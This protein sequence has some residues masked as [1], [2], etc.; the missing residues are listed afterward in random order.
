MKKK[1]LFVLHIPPPVH[2]SSIVGEQIK[3]SKKINQSFDCEFLNLS[4]SN[5]L[6]KIGSISFYKA[7]L[8][9]KIFSMVAFKSIK[10]N[11]DLVYIAPTV[12]KLGFLKDFFIVF[13]L[14]LFNKKVIFHLHNKGVAKRYKGYAVDLLYKYFFKNTKV[15]LLSNFLYDDIKEFVDKKDIYICPNGI[16]VIENLEIDLENKKSS[17]VPKILFL[18]NLIIS[19]GVIDLMEACSI[20][21]KRKVPFECN[22]I[23]GEADLDLL[24]FENIKVNLNIVDEVKYLGK[25]YGND[26]HD[27]FLNSDLFVFPTYYH[28][29]TFGLVLIE[30][31]QYAL[32]IITSDEGG[33]QDVVKDNFN[34]F[35]TEKQNPEDLA[36]KI[37]EMIRNKNRMIVFGKKGRKE[38]LDKFTTVNFET[39][40][41]EILETVINS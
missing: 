37:Q 39:N 19:K 29:E 10:N 1:I 7:Y 27:F 26:K 33:I 35:I 20:L 41:K 40:L 30:A 18:S 14:K 8:Y 23:G 6:N 31:M 32:P 21:K 38:F 11:Y 17:K 4:T 24:T 5:S 2:G 16:D 36:N 28:N 34:G 12:S 22:F 9:F 3:N 13:I 25:K 15:I